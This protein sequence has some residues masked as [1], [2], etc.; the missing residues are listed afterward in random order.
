M[1]TATLGQWGNALAVR[2]PMVFCEELD[3]APGKIVDMEVKDKQLVIRNL[4]D[5]STLK[6]RME[7]WDGVFYHSE[8]LEWGEPKGDELW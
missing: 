4:D 5:A 1:A 2:I 6:G 7:S 8:E 3:F